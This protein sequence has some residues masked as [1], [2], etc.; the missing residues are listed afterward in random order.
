[1][2]LVVVDLPQ[3]PFQQALETL[4]K[5][6]PE[7]SEVPHL[8]IYVVV[9]GHEDELPLKDLPRNV[10][11]SFK[12]L[13]TTS[14]TSFSYTDRGKNLILIKIPEDETFLLTNKAA[15]QG[16]L[17]H[18]LMHSILRMRGFDD[19]LRT[20]FGKVLNETLPQIENLPYSKKSVTSFFINIGKNSILVLKDLYANN[21]LI[22]K[23]F[24]RELLEYYSRLFGLGKTC[25][26]PIFHKIKEGKPLKQREL[27]YLGDIISFE[28]QLIPAWLPFL[29]THRR[30]ARRL[31]HH[32]YQCFEKDLGFIPGTFHEIQ[33]LYL[34]EFSMTCQFQEDYYRQILNKCYALLGGVDMFSLSLGEALEAIWRRKS[35]DDDGR[36]IL[37]NV[38]TSYFLHLRTHKDKKSRHALEEIKKM[39]RLQMSPKE[40]GAMK[41]ITKDKTEFLKLPILLS[42]IKARHE[43]LERP[44]SDFIDVAFFCARAGSVVLPKSVFAITARRL[45]RLD[46]SSPYLLVQ[47]LLSLELLYER[48]VHNLSL[49]TR[50]P[51]KLIASFKK[52][53]VIPT[54][55]TVDIALSI[56]RNIHNQNTNDP[57]VLA[58]ICSS[59]LKLTI[60]DRPLLCASLYAL[61]FKSHVIKDVVSYLEE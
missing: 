25:P 13:S 61:G 31:K 48:D 43:F 14:T 52:Y 26:L 59:L 29:K 4:E 3:K 23:G 21:E 15:L 20:C 28:L 58:F 10:A 24:A 6:L 38:L 11:D 47:Q 12:L 56:I 50:I 36:A 53:D 57:L 16:L 39:M 34:T 32:I 44:R 60:K 5:R 18:E 2:K 51:S 54:N 7:I 35:L 27:P 19:I 9:E 41:F 30:V 40:F 17:A 33:L 45:S 1:M 46:V 22:R 37:K 55:R 49:P 42:L 8:S